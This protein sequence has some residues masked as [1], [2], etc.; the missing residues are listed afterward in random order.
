MERLAV[1]AALSEPAEFAKS[2]HILMKGSI[3]SAVEGD[4]RAALRAKAM[5]RRL[6]EEHRG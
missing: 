4:R 1:D 3:V 2:W 5:A 6:I